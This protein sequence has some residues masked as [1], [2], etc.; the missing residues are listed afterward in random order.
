MTIGAKKAISTYLYIEGFRRHI[1][2]HG[3][4]QKKPD[5]KN[6]GKHFAV[7]GFCLIFA[8]LLLHLDR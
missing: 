6:N 3:W 5:G 8:T 2:A 4:H 7:S 1:K